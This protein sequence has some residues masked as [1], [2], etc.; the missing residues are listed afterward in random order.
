MFVGLALAHSLPTMSTGNDI[1][2]GLELMVSHET[3]EAK[4][5]N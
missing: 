1:E 2:G 4:S 3:M 5:A